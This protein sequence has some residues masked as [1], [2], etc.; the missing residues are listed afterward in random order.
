MSPSP[1]KPG[2]RRPTIQQSV[3]PQCDVRP[4]PNDFPYWENGPSLTR[5]LSDTL[6]SRQR[7]WSRRTGCRRRHQTPGSSLSDWTV[8]SAAVIRRAHIATWAPNR[9]NRGMAP[10]QSQHGAADGELDTRGLTK[11][12]YRFTKDKQGVCYPSKPSSMGYP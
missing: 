8:G 3:P 5:K 11:Q 12:K 1:L 7:R 6:S 9:P 2:G 10:P 4:S